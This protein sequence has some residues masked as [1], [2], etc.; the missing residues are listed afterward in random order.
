MRSYAIKTGKPFLHDQK[1]SRHH[2]D[3]DEHQEGFDHPLE[4]LRMAA[5]SSLRSAQYHMR[6][7]Q[8]NHL[9]NNEVQTKINLGSNRL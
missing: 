8:P 1:Q 7:N 4:H 2:K 6:N 9:L 3:Q 5:F